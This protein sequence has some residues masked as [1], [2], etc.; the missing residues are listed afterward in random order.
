MKTNLDSIGEKGM[1]EYVSSFA[2]KRVEIKTRVD[3][4]DGK[5]YLGKG[6]DAASPPKVFIEPCTDDYLI[7]IPVSNIL[8]IKTV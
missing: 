4:Y 6:G 1:Y 2:G 5:L 7:E 3:T 8:R